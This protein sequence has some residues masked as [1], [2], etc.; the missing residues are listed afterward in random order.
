ML[1]FTKASAS[2]SFGFKRDLLGGIMRSVELNLDSIAVDAGRRQKNP[3][4]THLI[5][6][7][8]NKKIKIKNRLYKIFLR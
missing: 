3:W 1:H 6:E 8:P 2:N 4:S 7:I 5:W